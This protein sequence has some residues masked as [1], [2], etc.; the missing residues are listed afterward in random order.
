MTVA[1]LPSAAEARRLRQRVWIGATCGVAGVILL[2]AAR[3]YEVNPL[4]FPACLL[5]V[6]AYLVV[7]P[8]FVARS[9]RWHRVI[10]FLPLIVYVLLLGAVAIAAAGTLSDNPALAGVALLGLW[11]FH[12][13]SGAPEPTSFAFERLAGR[14]TWAAAFQAFSMVCGTV[15][16][17]FCITR[18]LP[19]PERFEPVVV[20]TSLGA[21]VGL[22]TA[23]LKVF[24]RVRKLGTQLASNAGRM[25][26]CLDRLSQGAV[27]E[28][29]R[30][31][32]AAEDAWDALELTLR[33]KIQTGF[34]LSGTFLIPTEDR[35]S[36]EA[37][38]TEAIACPGTP[39]CREAV[40]QLDMLR[41]ACRGKIDTV[42]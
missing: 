42:A 15:G 5:V 21:V 22:G 20:G 30:L 16:L 31:Q 4:N 34:H 26:R 10:T 28:R 38:V 25:V 24:A 9:E 33:S 19:V 3:L 8:W 13:S 41:A 7:K 27:T 29:R 14:L 17:V 40:A 11:G 36:L 35:R 32:E 18:A 2:A 37:L 1:S 12:V 39:L 23:L 6:G